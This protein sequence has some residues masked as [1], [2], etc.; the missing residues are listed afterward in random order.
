MNSKIINRI[1]QGTLTLAVFVIFTSAG[2]ISPSGYSYDGADG[3]IN[4]VISDGTMDASKP[5]P[6]I[7]WVSDPVQPG[8]VVMVEG[9]NWGD[10]PRIELSWLQDDKPGQP[11]PFRRA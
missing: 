2:R 8:E 3:E 10:S 11:L 6:S 7:F 5:L 1:I 9:A 4:A